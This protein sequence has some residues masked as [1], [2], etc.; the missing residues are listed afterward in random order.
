MHLRIRSERGCPRAAYRFQVTSSRRDLGHVIIEG[1]LRSWESGRIC[2]RLASSC[3][4]LHIAPTA[5]T[6]TRVDA[7]GIGVRLL[8]DLAALGPSVRPGLF[9]EDDALAEPV[10]VALDLEEI[11]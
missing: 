11:S 6:P 4:C 8:L 5:P 3:H 2:T 1:L 9:V 7:E 10:F